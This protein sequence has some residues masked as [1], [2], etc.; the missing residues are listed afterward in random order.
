MQRCKNVA[1]VILCVVIELNLYNQSK[2]YFAIPVTTLQKRCN[3]YL[4]V[5]NRAKSQYLFKKNAKI[6]CKN[7]ISLI[8]HVLIQLNLIINA[9]KY[10]EY[11]K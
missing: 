4:M 10:F 3:V 5:R 11:L 2:I 6:F 7:I 1:T 8:L 9:K